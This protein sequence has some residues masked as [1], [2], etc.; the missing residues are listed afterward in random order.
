MMVNVFYMLEL[1]PA[2]VLMR[3]SSGLLLIV[4]IIGQTQS[5]IT[6]AHFYS[7]AIISLSVLGLSIP[8]M[9]TAFR[10]CTAFKCGVTGSLLQGPFLSGNF[11]GLCFVFCG[12]LLLLVPM[13]WAGRICVLAFVSTALVATVARTSAVALGLAVG[14]YMLAR[15]FER[16]A[17]SA[18][19]KFVAGLASIAVT[20]VP[21]TIGVYLV[22]TADQFALS[23]RGRVW[24]L[25]RLAAEDNPMSGVGLDAWSF[26]QE[27]GDVSTIHFTH[28]FYLL[29]LFS[30]G[31]IAL[32]LFTMTMIRL[33][34]NGI[35]DWQSV[36]RGSLL[37]IVFLVCGITEGTWNPLTVDGL[38]WMFFATVAASAANSLSRFER[39]RHLSADEVEAL[40]R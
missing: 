24:A 36:G 26:L 39:D 5:R 35:V 16:Q 13:S 33:V 29:L 2:T 15:V 27:T 40:A 32:S 34:Y 19:P 6:A 4:F 9:S 12:A 37:P 23:N 17:H 1:A 22:Y 3:G 31:F 14:V 18:P 38:S 28:S 7:A 11:M 20:M 30:G 10:P 8:L 25:G 21:V